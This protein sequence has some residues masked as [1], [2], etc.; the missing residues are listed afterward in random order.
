M[1]GPGT[2]IK[3]LGGAAAVV[4]A[5]GLGAA[6]VVSMLP[7]TPEGM[8]KRI[9]DDFDKNGDS[10]INVSTSQSNPKTDERVAGHKGGSRYESAIVLA[11]ADRDGNSKVAEPELLETL[12][13]LDE[14][15]DGK[16]NGDETNANSPIFHGHDREEL[17]YREIDTVWQRINPDYGANDY[18]ENGDG[19]VVDA[20][21]PNWS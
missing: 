10:F 11:M 14:N 3:A 18:E 13:Y 8:T 15:G 7:K 12:E 16:F 19:H 4:V 2:M 17:D 21:D 9:L 20:S 1:K 5:A 6:T